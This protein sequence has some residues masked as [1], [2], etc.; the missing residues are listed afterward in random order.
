MGK[1][2]GRAGCVRQTKDEDPVT[3]FCLRKNKKPEAAIRS[4][5]HLPFPEAFHWIVFMGKGR[6]RKGGRGK[7]G[8]ARVAGKTGKEWKKVSPRISRTLW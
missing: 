4:P 5:G 8:R 6:F 7:D 1:Q 2:K 3:K